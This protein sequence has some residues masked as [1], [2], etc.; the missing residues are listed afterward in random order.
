MYPNFLQREFVKENCFNTKL[1]RYTANP[2]DD[3][4]PSL[5]HQVS[6]QNMLHSKSRRHSTIIYFPPV[7]SSPTAVDV[8]VKPS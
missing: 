6:G 7:T 3:R 8:V 5:L 2:E 4:I 1:L